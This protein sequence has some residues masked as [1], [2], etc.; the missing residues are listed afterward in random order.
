MLMSAA[1][2]VT[3]GALL[4]GGAFKPATL[5]RGPK[6]DVGMDLR[7]LLFGMMAYFGGMLLQS[8]VL[9]AWLGFSVDPD[10]VPAAIE[11]M[12]PTEQAALGL[13]GQLTMWAPAV[14][15]LLWRLK[16]SGYLRLG[17]VVPRHPLRDLGVGAL[18]VW[19]AYILTWGMGVVTVLI[20]RLAG[21]EPPD[22]G[23]ET[24]RMMAEA[25]SIMVTVLLTVSAVVVAPIAEE[26]FFRGLLQTGLQSALGHDK[27]WLSILPV[28]VFFGLVHVGAVPWAMVPLLVLLGVIFGWV[29]E[30]T[31]SLW[32]AVLV[33]AG[34]NGLSILLSHLQH[35]GGG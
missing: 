6:R 23:H 21:S 30:R 10:S 27:R 22:H 17:G 26:F 11:A 18:G 24:L 13:V 34:Y 19:V 16:S 31:G 12:S 8:L 15:Y 29:Y 25:D 14:G 33:H 7:D 1:F 5:G 20:I 32:C 2:F 28:A 3:L 9:V 35:A 4:R